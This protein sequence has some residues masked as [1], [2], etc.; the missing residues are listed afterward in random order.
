MW[1]RVIRNIQRIIDRLRGK[2]DD[3]YPASSDPDMPDPRRPEAYRTGFLWKP[4]GDHNRPAVALLPSAFTHKTARVMVMARNGGEVERAG[5]AHN[6]HIQPNGNREHYRFRRQ[7]ASYAGPMDLTVET[8]DGNFWT[9]QV[10]SPAQRH[11]SSITPSVRGSGQPRPQPEPHPEP[12]PDPQ[13]ADQ[14]R[15]EPGATSTRITVPRRFGMW[16]LGVLSLSPHHQLWGPTRTSEH[17]VTVPFGGKQLGQ[18]ALQHSR[19]AALLIHA[20][21]SNET[22]GDHRSAS[23]RIHDPDRIYVGDETRVKPGERPH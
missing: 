13:P 10:R 20:N 4:I 17:T 16:Q 19:F 21:T 7:G 18:M 9:W 12:Q 3:D 2:D 15:Y 6:D 22:T 23:W 14:F 5:R 11:D 8:N 1:S